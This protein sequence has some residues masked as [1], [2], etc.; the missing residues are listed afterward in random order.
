MR[1]KYLEKSKRKC[2]CR[3]A[4]LLSERAKIFSLKMHEMRVMQFENY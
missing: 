4:T 2:V 1:Q 3:R